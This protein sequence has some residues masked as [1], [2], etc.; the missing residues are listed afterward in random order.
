MSTPVTQ[1]STPHKSAVDKAESTVGKCQRILQEAQLWGT[2]LSKRTVFNRDLDPS[3]AH[4]RHWR[5][6]GAVITLAIT[7]V[8]G[9]SSYLH[10]KAHCSRAPIKKIGDI[11]ED[12][13]A[14]FKSYVGPRSPTIV[15]S[16][17][18]FAATISRHLTIPPTK[19]SVSGD[20]DDQVGVGG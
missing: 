4:C 5:R 13:C 6:Q 11:P 10:V 15:D 1:S 12:S 7:L 16:N 18:V 9:P 14:G 8:Q 2:S 20:D 17:G 19:A 3:S